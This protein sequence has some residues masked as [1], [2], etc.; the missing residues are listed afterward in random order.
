MDQSDSGCDEVEL[1]PFGRPAKNGATN[2]RVWPSH[3][4]FDIGSKYQ[5]Q[6]HP[7]TRFQKLRLGEDRPA[8]NKYAE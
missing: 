5:V 3:V 1:K 4:T 2:V 8:G 7:M 6:G